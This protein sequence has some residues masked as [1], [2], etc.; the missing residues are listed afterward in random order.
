MPLEGNL[1]GC[2]GNSFVFSFFLDQFCLL[3]ENIQK[4][5]YLQREFL[6]FILKCEFV[7]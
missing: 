4:K 3:L 1:F 2:R 6:I 5:S 7:V